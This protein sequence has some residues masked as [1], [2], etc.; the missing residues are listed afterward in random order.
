MRAH[1]HLS[2][3]RSY[4]FCRGNELPGESKAQ[5]INFPDR[6]TSV[7]RLSA[8]DIFRVLVWHQLP[9]GESEDFFFSSNGHIF[10]TRHASRGCFILLPSNTNSRKHTALYRGMKLWNYLPSDI[11]S[12][13]RKTVFKTRQEIFSYKD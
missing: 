8:A 13:T 12:L 7:D 9:V 1:V 3:L 10:K 5:K 11:T 2:G 6:G 4:H